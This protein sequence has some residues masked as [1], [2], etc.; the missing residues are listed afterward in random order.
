MADRVILT[1]G[2]RKGVFVAEAAAPRLAE[3]L[4]HRKAP[5]LHHDP[6]ADPLELGLRYEDSRRAGLVREELDLRQER[7]HLAEIG[8][9]A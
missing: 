6:L 7:E 2:T 5:V 4:P 9:D 1:I 8:Q 3:E